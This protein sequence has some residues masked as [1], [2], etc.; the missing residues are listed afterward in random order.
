M[1]TKCPPKILVVKIKFRLNRL[2][3]LGVSVKYMFKYKATET[4]AALEMRNV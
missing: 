1:V 2:L 4:G 3:F